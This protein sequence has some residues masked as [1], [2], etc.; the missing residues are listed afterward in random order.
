MKHQTL[1]HE[2]ITYHFQQTHEWHIKVIKVNL[3]DSVK[4]MVAPWEEDEY[5]IIINDKLPEDEQLR[6]FLH[7]MTHLYRG[8]L[9]RI[10]QDVSTIE[11]ETDR[12][13]EGLQLTM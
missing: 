10:G 1:E 3:P 12:I 7:E 8:D 6:S 13:M 9:D 2:G 4:G 5:R 11:E